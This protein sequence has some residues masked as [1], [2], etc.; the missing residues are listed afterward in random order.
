MKEIRGILKKLVSK[1]VHLGE[2]S[3]RHTHRHCASR[4][5]SRESLCQRGVLPVGKLVAPLVH[6]TRSTLHNPT[7][8]PTN[9]AFLGMI[10]LSG[11]P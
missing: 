9:A 1:R 4:V 6:H 2:R 3:G 5:L 11:S 10:M 7:Y 8:S